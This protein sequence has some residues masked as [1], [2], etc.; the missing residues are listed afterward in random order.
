MRKYLVIGDHIDKGRRER[1]RMRVRALR[2]RLE[3]EASHDALTGL[4]NRGLF[5]ERTEQ[6]LEC[7]PDGSML[8]VLFI[9]L[10]DFKAINDGVGHEVGDRVLA[11][12]AARLQECL[13]PTDLAARVGGDE[14]GL[15]I[16]GLSGQADAADARSG[17][18]DDSSG[19]CLT[20]LLFSNPCAAFGTDAGFVAG[21][22]VTA[23][24][25]VAGAPT[26]RAAPG[27]GAA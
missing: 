11:S 16:E 25:A 7:R 4:P 21:E 5:V 1:S 12:V 8:A 20:A 2:N 3:H 10:D 27:I 6:A 15:L 19:H 23:G 13:S 14:F 22:V 18:L 9:D 24:A 26:R 17:H